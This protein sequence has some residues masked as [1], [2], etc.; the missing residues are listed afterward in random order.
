M[1]HWL[2][3][4]NNEALL[5]AEYDDECLK[6]VAQSCVEAATALKKA[7]D[8]V[9]SI[10]PEEESKITSE[11][12]EQLANLASALDSSSDPELKKQASVL[13]ELLL[14]IASPPGALAE[15]KSAEDNRLEDLK[16]KYEQPRE[17]LKKSNKI[18]DSEKAIEKSQMTKDYEINQH[19][20]S[21]RYCPS[22][23]GVQISR[24][25]ENLWQCELDKQIFDFQ[26]GYTLANG[27]KVSGGD[28]SNQTKGTDIPSHAIFDTRDGRLNYNK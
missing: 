1:A 28:V 12:I 19:G 15:K 4:P 10:E 25:S 23:P 13:D 14:T 18:A 8:S 9:D 2:E 26:N 6:I 11:S 16:K 7:A 5:L 24:V 22:H 21:S 3:S 17:D 20:L 27:T